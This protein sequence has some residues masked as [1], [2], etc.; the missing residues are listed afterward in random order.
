VHETRVIALWAV[1]R[2]VSTTFEKAF[3]Q[4]PQA[5]VVHE[6][7]TDCY[8]FGSERRS[9]RYGV[10]PSKLGCDAA[11]ALDAVTRERAPVVFVKDL[12]FQAEP[13]LSDDVLRGVSN[14]FILRHP[15]AVLRS[16]LPLKPDFTE[17]EFGFTALRRLWRRVRGM[18][19]DAVV[20]EG[21]GFRANPASVLRAYCAKVGVGFVPQML[22]WPDG[23]IRPWDPTEAESQAKWHRTLEASLGV[24]P[25]HPV[26][27]VEVSADRR[28]LYA[29]ALDIYESLATG[30]V[31][32]SE[33]LPTRA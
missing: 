30:A 32:V 15:A 10:Q 5:R 13:Y 17:D 33:T 6:P 22:H 25:P 16:L 3:S 2:S 18:G 12:A 31:G 9:G 19:L 4:H 29:R 20:V 7:F 14:T 21:D 27:E 24:L 1:P 26:Q 23:R 8:Y 28:C 11:N